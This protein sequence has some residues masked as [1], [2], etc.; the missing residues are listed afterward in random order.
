MTRV[1]GIDPGTVR[2]GVA[3]SDS[4]AS[5]AFP[6]PALLNDETLIEV[7]R[8]LIDDERVATLVVGRPVAL[9]GN[10]TASTQQADALY[11][12]LEEAF[13]DLVLTQWDERLTTVQAER[14][15]SR[16]GLKAK[17]HREHVDSAAAVIML[18]NY[19][20]GRHVL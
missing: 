20:D 13:A 6:R 19:L 1:L 4:A 8:D 9:P 18:Q 17:E 5:M 2:C 16:A 12:Q 15:L 7:L 10:E 3:I 11:H 14:S